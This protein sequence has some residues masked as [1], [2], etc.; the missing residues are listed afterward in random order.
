MRFIAPKNGQ[1]RGVNYAKDYE[2][3]VILAT[4]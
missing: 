4:L 2:L 3:E 1:T